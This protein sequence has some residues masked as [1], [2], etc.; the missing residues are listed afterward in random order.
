MMW[1]I[2][3]DGITA[4]FTFDQRN[5]L[6]IKRVKNGFNLSV[7]YSDE[8][9]NQEASVFKNNRKGKMMYTKFLGDNQLL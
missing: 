6:Y 9:M 1:N 7:I 8:S 3:K 2:E 5:R 4:V